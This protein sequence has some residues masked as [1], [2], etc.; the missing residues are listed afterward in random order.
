M[1]YIE[2][3]DAR[4][5]EIGLGTLQNKGDECRNTAQTALDVGYRHIDTAQSYNNE[6]SVGYGIA[7]ADVDREEIFLTTKVWRSNLRHDDVIESVHES[8]N[9]LNVDY[10]DHLLIHWP[11]PRVPVEETLAAMEELKD[12]RLVSHLV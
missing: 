8:L 10:V 9:R 7:A 3:G 12:E 11:H 4:I 6:A 1:E 5:P 2:I